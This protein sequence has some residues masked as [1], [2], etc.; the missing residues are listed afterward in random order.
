MEIKIRRSIFDND[1]EFSTEFI[2]N[3]NIFYGYNSGRFN[4]CWDEGNLKVDLKI[5][6]PKDMRRLFKYIEEQDLFL[7]NYRDIL[8]DY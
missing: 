2:F 5:I 1:S 4:V 3:K 7:K 6:Y 8:L